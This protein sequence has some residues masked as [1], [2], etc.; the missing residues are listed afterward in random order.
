MKRFVLVEIILSVCFCVLFAFSVYFFVVCA[1]MFAE[2]NT[3]IAVPDVYPSFF[4]PSTY[5]I[6]YDSAVEHLCFGLVF[7]LSSILDLAAM[8]LIAVF[9]LPGIR[10][11]AEKI[12]AKKTRALPCAENSEAESDEPKN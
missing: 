9:P 2:W 6:I 8:I 11:L 7:L 1:K 12:R 5:R 3:P 10:P 4:D